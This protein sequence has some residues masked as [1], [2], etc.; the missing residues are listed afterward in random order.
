MKILR[1]LAILAVFV[2]QSGSARVV[3]LGR[4]GAVYPIAEPDVLKDIQEAASRVDWQKVFDQKRFEERIKAF[5]PPDLKKLPRAKEPRVRLVDL[6]WTLPFDIPKVNERGEIVGI[7]YPKG[8]TFNPLDYVTYPRTL[9]VI[10]ADDPLQLEWFERSRYLND[11]EV[12]LLLSGGS[13]YEVSQRLKRPV[14]YAFGFVVERLKIE[15]VPSVLRQKGRFME[16]KEI[17]VEAELKKMRRG[18][19]RSAS[20]R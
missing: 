15:K 16:V 14:F 19:P 11:P 4:F 13:W 2:W 5:R 9:V 6:T 18:S 17:D 10:D 20:G 3:N 8:Y 7:L 12:T 1:V